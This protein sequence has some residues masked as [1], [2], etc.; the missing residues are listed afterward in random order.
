MTYLDNAATAPLLPAVR[1]A[2]EPWWGRPVNP[3]SAHRDGQRAAAALERARAQVAALLGRPAQG[4]VFTSGATEANH[5]ALYAWTQTVGRRVAAAAIEHPSIAGALERAEAQVVPLRVGGD[6]RIDTATLPDVDVVC[7][8]A[9]NHE[10]GVLQALPASA[11]LH[12]DATQAVGKG[13]LNLAP[14]ASVAISA[15]KLGGPAGIGAL[16]LRDADAVPGWQRGGAHER[17]R[18][19]G[20]PDVISAIGFGAACEAALDHGA[21]RRVRWA[22]WSGRVE[23]AVLA[24]GGRVAGIGAP[25]VPTH[26]C[27]VFPG[28]PGETLVQGLD[29]RGIAVSSGAACASGSSEPSPVLVAMGDPDPGSA[30]RISLGPG[31]AEADIDALIAALPAVVAAVRAA[32]EG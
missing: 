31:T 15:H 5:H 21:A 32:V 8:M 9:A 10:T 24:C 30:V 3:A 16:S 7:T 12:V 23:V 11:V 28:L 4:V 17:G 1:A 20:T 29:L 13:G 26:T 18:R 25:R 22:A 27:A 6:G 19:A 2:M 14:A